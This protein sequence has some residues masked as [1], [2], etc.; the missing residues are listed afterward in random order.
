[1]ARR[2]NGRVLAVDPAGGR[3]SFHAAIL[4]YR[5]RGRELELVGHVL[6]PLLALARRRIE[7]DM[8]L[9]FL[10][11]REVSGKLGAYEPYRVPGTAE[12]ALP[13]ARADLSELGE[14]EMDQIR[15]WR[16]ETVG[17]LVFNFWD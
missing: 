7:S 15:Y 6:L 14:A 1:M 13:V 3:R 17:E 12:L 11:D 4:T 9:S 2:T 16:P 8:A 10:D 5:D